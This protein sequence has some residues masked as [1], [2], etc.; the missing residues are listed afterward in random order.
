M[1]HAMQGRKDPAH[2]QLVG[3]QFLL[4][5]SF[6]FVSSLVLSRFIKKVSQTGTPFI[7]HALATEL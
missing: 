3:H 5:V 6:S 2:L 7:T 1:H 4:L